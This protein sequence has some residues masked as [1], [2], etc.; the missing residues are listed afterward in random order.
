MSLHPFLDRATPVGFAHRGGAGDAPENTLAA[1]EAAIALGYRYLETDAQVTREGTVVAFHDDRLERVTDREG[2]IADLDL[3]DVQTADA[4]YRFSLD[5]GHSHPHRGRGLTIP[6]LEDLLMRWPD[7]RLNIDVQT[8]RGMLALVDLVDRFGAW[9]RICL[10]SLS[11]ARQRRIRVLSRGRACCAMAPGALAIAHLT[12]LCGLMPRLG[13][14]CIQLSLGD[15]PTPIIT[16]QLIHAAHRVGLPV[17][18][19]TVNDERVMHE[20]LDLG[21]DGIMTDRP[22]LLRAVFAARSLDVGGKAAH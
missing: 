18:A 21:I 9:D 17:H 5:G 11:R 15:G 13:A 6:R 7:A 8:D 16:T 14:D 3:A 19:W 20:L 10:G 22:R 2:A 12:A 4:G 1:F